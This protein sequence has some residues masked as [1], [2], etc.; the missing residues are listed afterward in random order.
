MHFTSDLLANNISLPVC[1]H[2]CSACARLLSM[3]APTDSS[4]PSRRQLKY[5]AHD[6][7]EQ[8]PELSSNVPLFSGSGKSLEIKKQEQQPVTTDSIAATVAPMPITFEQMRILLSDHSAAILEQAKTAA[9]DNEEW[10]RPH[11]P[12]I[13]CRNARSAGSGEI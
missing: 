9:M 12:L 3:L 8:Q 7:N 4:L 13:L 5:T 2:L 1:V 10:K 6:G 11:Y